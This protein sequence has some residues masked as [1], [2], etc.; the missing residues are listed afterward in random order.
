LNEANRP[1]FWWVNIQ[2]HASGRAELSPHRNPHEPTSSLLSQ[3]RY[4]IQNIE[5]NGMELKKY[6][7]VE[8]M[9]EK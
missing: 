2:R 4:K 6:E 5:F 1:S 9:F 7:K 8:N 3:Q